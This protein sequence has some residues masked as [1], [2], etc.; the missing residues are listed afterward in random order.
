MFKK[1]KYPQQEKS[2]TQLVSLVNSSAP[3]KMNTNLHKLLQKIEE[4]GNFTT[5]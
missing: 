4:E 3:G 5:C 2:Q 1:K